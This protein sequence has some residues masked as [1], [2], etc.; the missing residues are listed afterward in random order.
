MVRI[1]P[2]EFSFCLC[3]F[4]NQL[5]FPYIWMLW[6]L[7]GSVV[8]HY[9]WLKYRSITDLEDTF[10]FLSSKM[11]ISWTPNLKIIECQN[12]HY[13]FGC[14]LLFCFFWGGSMLSYGQGSHLEGFGGIT[15]T[16]ASQQLVMQTHSTITWASRSLLFDLQTENKH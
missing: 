5:N 15:E 1:W 10:L 14:W 8:S 6:L 9:W 16:K 7:S 13:F 3:A 12:N 11:S 4:Q 2:N